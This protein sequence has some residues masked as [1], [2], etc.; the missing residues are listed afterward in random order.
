MA[1]RILA[2]L[3]LAM[4]AGQLSDISG[5]VDALAVYEVGGRPASWVLAISIVAAEAMSG[6]GLLRRGGTLRRVAPGVAVVVAVA[7]TILGVQ[8]FARGLVLDNCGCFGVHLA[9]PL[10]W[11]VLLEDAEF[12]ALAWWVRRKDTLTGQ[13]DVGG[14]PRSPAVSRRANSSRRLSDSSGTAGASRP[15]DALISK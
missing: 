5:F 11:W 9:Q 10:R 14:S 3:L 8:A 13:A 4:T 1:R 7:W 12:I 2:V 6:V 15:S